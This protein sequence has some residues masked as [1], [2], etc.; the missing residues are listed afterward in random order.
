MDGDDIY[1]R[2]KEPLEKEK[3]YLQLFRLNLETCKETIVKNH[4][5]WERDYYLSP[6]FAQGFGEKDALYIADGYHEEF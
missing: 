2:Q 6:V 1:A 4:I 3:T 5:F